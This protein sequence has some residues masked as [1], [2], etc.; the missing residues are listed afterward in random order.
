MNKMDTT[1]VALS[2]LIFVMA[3]FLPTTLYKMSFSNILVPLILLVLLLLVVRKSP[4]GSIVLLLAI[5][6]L[7]AE[8]RVRV[9]NM[10]VPPDAPPSYEA[11]LAPAPPIVPDEVH[12][13]PKTPRG[14]MVTYKPSEDATNEFEPVDSTINMKK[15]M[16]S[17]RVSDDANKFL[18]Q[19]GLI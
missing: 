15:A 17:P 1:L 9:I 12:P 6:S 16:D 19:H 14:P 4:I 5:M 13:E 3:P 8:Y 2:F 7:F 10:S 18:I 11:Q